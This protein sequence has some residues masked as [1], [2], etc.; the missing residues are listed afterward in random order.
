[1]SAVQDMHD[2]EVNGGLA[3][4]EGGKIL[5]YLGCPLDPPPRTRMHGEA[6]VGTFEEAEAWLRAWAREHYGE[7]LSPPPTTAPGHPIVQRL[8]DAR[9]PGSVYWIYDGAFG[10]TLMDR[11]D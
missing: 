6:L 4:P 1:M 3:W 2:M 10:M 11:E 5:V 9:I 8:F 7:T